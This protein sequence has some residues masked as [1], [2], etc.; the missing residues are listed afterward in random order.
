M[1]ADLVP[2]ED[3]LRGLQMDDFFF[4]YL[5]MVEREKKR[6]EASTL[7]SLLRRAL[8]PS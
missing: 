6:E 7:M 3:F 5:N 4:L 2:G 1:A 8:I